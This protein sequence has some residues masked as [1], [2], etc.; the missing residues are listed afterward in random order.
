MKLTQL[1]NGSLYVNPEHISYVIEEFDPGADRTVPVVH[2]TGG[3]RFRLVDMTITQLA[4]AFTGEE[5][6]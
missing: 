2:M 1:G 4:S 5:V 6:Q 3:M